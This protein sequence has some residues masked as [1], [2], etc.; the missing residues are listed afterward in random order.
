MKKTIITSL[1]ILSLFRVSLEPLGKYFINKSL[2]ESF[3]SLEGQISDFNISLI[4]G[5]YKIDNLII[6][7][8][9]S[10]DRLPF[11]NIEKFSFNVSWQALL[12]GKLSLD[13]LIENAKITIVK[14]KDK[15]QEQIPGEEKKENW[16]K[17]LKSVIPLK[18]QSIAIVDITLSYQD[19]S[20]TGLEKTNLFISKG[21]IT[22]LLTPK[23]GESKLS[24]LLV[25]GKLNNQ[26]S[27]YLRGGV[28]LSRKENYFDLD[29]K[30]EKFDL[31]SLNKLMLSYIPLDITK[32]ELSIISEFKGDS[33][34]AK[35]YAKIFLEDL[36]VVESDQ[37]FKGTPHFFIEYLGGF[38][39]W[40]LSV[41]SDSTIATE[42]PFSIDKG[43]FKIDGSEAFWGS[44]ENSIDKLEKN[45]KN[46]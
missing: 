3:D 17:A 7:K 30:L 11:L 34:D 19:N 45:F 2:R 16:I 8:I 5:S 23:L 20:I 14:S 46:L 15:S 22:N 33:K 42:L 37:R 6:D 29:L 28:D 25:E 27:L 24:S 44:L 31:N 18:V 1:I 35:G 10:N 38:T 41:I 40:I 39:G 36:D 13:A 26:A 43:E 4:S 9:N 12:E 21:E 32:G